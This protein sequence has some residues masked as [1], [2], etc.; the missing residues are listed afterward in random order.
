[1]IFLL[2]ALRRE[3]DNPIKIQ[4]IVANFDVGE[5]LGSGSFG[6]VW[7]IK[8][9]KTQDYFALKL[10]AETAY[11]ISMKCEIEVLKQC[12]GSCNLPK[13]YYFGKWNYQYYIIMNYVPHDDFMEILYSF[14]N[15]EIVE[16]AKNL[17]IALEY[18]HDRN[19]IHRDVKPGNF[20]YNRREKKYMLVDFGLSSFYKPIEENILTPVQFN[21]DNRRSST[22]K[23]KLSLNEM[24]VE[25]SHE[26]NIK[27]RNVDTIDERD[28]KYSTKVKN[29]CNCY[30][31]ELMVDIW[32]AGCT[33]LSIA[34][35]L[36]SFFR[37][38]DEFQALFQYACIVG[39]DDLKKAAN[40]W[41]VDLIISL[42]SSRKSFYLISKAMKKKSIYSIKDFTSSGCYQ[43]RN[44]L[45]DNPD[46][47]C[48]CFKNNC[49]YPYEDEYEK[50]VIN[51]INW[52]LIS[53]PKIRYSAKDIL[54]CI[55]DFENSIKKKKHIEKLENSVSKM[56][57]SNI[58]KILP[59]VHVFS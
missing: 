50:M 8:N 20:L 4:E 23:R 29:I 38:A 47:I 2:M 52:C 42:Q 41:N 48:V 7:K 30:D 18:L 17:F 44:Y 57:Q 35:Q 58:L 33:I 10:S 16:Y 14:T 37:P 51:I 54:E 34:C 43:C 22:T 39:T 13:P 53:H 31:Q 12:N 36:P 49:T 1:Y 28:Q 5:L 56:L 6:A 26:N 9:K 11:P 15:K 25:G 45:I 40:Y 32:S 19:I 3:P 55:K 24:E 59:T 27:R 46:G 21:L